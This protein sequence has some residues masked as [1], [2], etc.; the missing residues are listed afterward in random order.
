MISIDSVDYDD[1]RLKTWGG[2]EARVNSVTDA[3]WLVQLPA[4][5]QADSSSGLTTL[6]A[7]FKH[8]DAKHKS[9]YSN[10]WPQASFQAPGM[11]GS[12]FQEKKIAGESKTSIPKDLNDSS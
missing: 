6:Q 1:L 3:R 4:E 12:N 2:E 10:F 9:R 8:S 11:E 5:T 7:C